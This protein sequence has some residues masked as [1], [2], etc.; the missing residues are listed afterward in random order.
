MVRKN[1]NK[2]TDRELVVLAEVLKGKTNQ[3]ISNKFFITLHTVKAHIKNILQKTNC[4][5]RSELISKLF[6]NYCD[7]TLSSEDIADV[8]LKF[9]KKI[10]IKNK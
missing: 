10:Q 9:F 2:L 4:T 7:I 1:W 5:H 3:E 6:V 8:I